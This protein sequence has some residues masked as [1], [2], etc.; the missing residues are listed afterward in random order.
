MAVVSATVYTTRDHAGN[1]RTEAWLTIEF[2]GGY[3]QQGN[4]FDLSPYFKR[5]DYIFT[6][7]MSGGVLRALLSGGAAAASGAIW[8][9][10]S[11]VQ[12]IATVDD[13][14]TPAS[15]RFQ[16]WATVQPTSGQASF[17]GITEIAS[18]PAAAISGIRF[19]ARAL[20]A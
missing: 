19:A 13:F 6:S 7:P 20:G 5:L 16:I 8:N 9:S 4:A 11:Q 14:A 17:P 18:G 12:V 3:V 1:P 2:T 10:G 15:A